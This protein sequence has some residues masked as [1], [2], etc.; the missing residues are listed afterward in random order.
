M[1]QILKIVTSSDRWS[2]SENNGTI[3]NVQPLMVLEEFNIFKNLKNRW[4]GAT[5]KNWKILASRKKIDDLQE[6]D[7]FKQKIF[8]EKKISKLR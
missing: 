6:L 8:F 2:L 4:W 7:N 5:T 1:G 3:T